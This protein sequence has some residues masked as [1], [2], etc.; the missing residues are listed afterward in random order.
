MKLRAIVTCVLFSFLVVFNASCNENQKMPSR[1]ISPSEYEFPYESHFGGT[2]Y[3][4]SDL[5]EPRPV[6]GKYLKVINGGLVVINS[7]DAG[8]YINMKLKDKIDKDIYVVTAYENP[9]DKNAPFVND[10]IVTPDMYAKTIEFSSPDFIKGLKYW[11]N[12]KVNVTVYEDKSMAKQ[13]DGFT[14]NIRSY[15]DTTVQPI[16]VMR[17]DLPRK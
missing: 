9:L 14:Q 3:K 16:K 2:H 4:G 17:V 10:F 13:I 8:F 15:V 5:T 1:L 11:R 12:Y 6:S 7:K